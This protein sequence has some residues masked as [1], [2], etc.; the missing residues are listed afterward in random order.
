MLGREALTLQESVTS[1]GSTRLLLG[2]IW[3]PASGL[4]VQGA[5]WLS[6]PWA[7]ASGQAPGPSALRVPPGQEPGALAPSSGAGT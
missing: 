4:E 7:E 1:P 5:Q 2:S 3:S 6:E